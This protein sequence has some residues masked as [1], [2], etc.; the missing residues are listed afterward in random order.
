VPKSVPAIIITKKISRGGCAFGPL[1][2]GINSKRVPF[3]KRHSPKFGYSKTPINTPGWPLLFF[4][5]FQV[6]KLKA[7]PLNIVSQEQL[8]VKV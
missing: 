3:T 8:W 2:L 1:F 4:H 6:F 7:F 5:N